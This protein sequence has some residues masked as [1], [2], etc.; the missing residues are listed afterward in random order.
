[1]SRP[2]ILATR[3]SNLALWQAR[4]VQQALHRAHPGL[5]VELR[6]I[7][8]TGDRFLDTPLPQLTGKGIFTLEIESALRSGEAD[9]AVHSLKDLPTELPEGLALGALPTREDPRDALVS[10]HGLPLAQLPPAS[11]VGTS[12]AR[13][14]NQLAHARPDLQFAP[15]RGNVET[16]LRRLHEGH[17]DAIV[18]AAAGLIRLGLE[19]A[20]S[21]YLSPE[22]CLPAAGQ[23]VLAVEVRQDDAELLALLVPLANAEVTACALAERAALRHL[24]GGC[25]AA[26]GVLGCVE[27]DRCYL[28]GAVVGPMGA[29]Y[30][31]DRVQGPRE[32]PELVGR[33]LA[34]RLL[35]AGAGAV[36][37]PPPPE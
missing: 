20:I 23:G 5:D 37:A 25:H 35:Q 9:L 12:S 36:V 8:T 34:E 4:W 1:M 19:G 29:P 16:R 18:V 14:T 15:L 22:V 33:T 10:R 2:L 3:G 31:R 7:K 6:I 26:F 11:I 17:L 21:E 27:G 13:R 24:G 30:F 32:D 28:E